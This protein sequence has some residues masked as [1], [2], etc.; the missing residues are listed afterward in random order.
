MLGRL[1]ISPSRS[2][3]HPCRAI[4]P[5]NLEGR[6][7]HSSGD[8]CDKKLLF[9]FEFGNGTVNCQRVRAQERR[10][11]RASASIG[12]AGGH[13]APRGTVLSHP[14]AAPAAMARRYCACSRRVTGTPW[15]C[16]TGVPFPGPRSG[17]FRPLC[18]QTRG[19]CPVS[20]RTSEF[21][22]CRRSF[23]KVGRGPFLTHDRWRENKAFRHR[24][25]RHCERHGSPMP[26]VKQK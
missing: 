14:R 6:R 17:T 3:S 20:R 18:V 23:W 26:A 2:S 13:S 1:G 22:C 15:R 10:G 21:P 4:T 11:H 16:G 9:G 25:G 24:P 5:Q 12:S 19:Q 8:A 7:C